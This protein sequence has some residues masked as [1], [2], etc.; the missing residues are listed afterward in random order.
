MSVYNQFFFELLSILT[1]FIYQNDMLHSSASTRDAI[2]TTKTCPQLRVCH[3][4]F[5]I[6]I[7]LR[8]KFFCKMDP[9]RVANSQ[10][11]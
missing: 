6:E 7:E 1:S 8:W 3:V 10:I 2:S 4:G 5:F 11:K 9:W